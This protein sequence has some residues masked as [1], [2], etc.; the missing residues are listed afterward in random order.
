MNLNIKEYC[1][2]LRRIRVRS[3]NIY[4]IKDKNGNYDIGK[5]DLI[6]KIFVKENL[7]GCSIC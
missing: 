4:D 3:I 6:E 2:W 5:L 7:D 1:I